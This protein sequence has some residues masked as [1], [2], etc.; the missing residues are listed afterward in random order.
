MKRTNLKILIVGFISIFVWEPLHALNIKTVC[1][2]DY[3]FFD[4]EIVSN[5]FKVGFG[6]EGEVIHIDDTV[7]L[8]YKSEAV[9]DLW[10]YYRNTKQLNTVNVLTMHN[11]YKGQKVLCR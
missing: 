8:A 2:D 11:G 4:L 1:K 5:K 6:F 7:V 9:G 10:V 3:G